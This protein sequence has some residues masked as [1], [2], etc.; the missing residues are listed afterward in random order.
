MHLRRIHSTLSST[1]QEIQRKLNLFL[2][3]QLDWSNHTKLGMR[4]DELIIGAVRRRGSWRQQSSNWYSAG[5]RRRIRRKGGSNRGCRRDVDYHRH[6][7]VLRPL[8]EEVFLDHLR[9]LCFKASL[10]NMGI[11]QLLVQGHQSLLIVRDIQSRL[12]LDVNRHLPNILKSSLCLPE[13]RRW[14]LLTE[15]EAQMCLEDSVLQMMS[16]G[17]ILRRTFGFAGAERELL[18]A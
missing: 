12:L 13:R 7:D 3:T 18:E 1:E 16:D 8:N 11:L 6:I 10:G 5:R 15:E 17:R 14:R 4:E 2:W 9:V